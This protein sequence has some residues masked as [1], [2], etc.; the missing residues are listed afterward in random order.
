[1][2]VTQDTNRVNSAAAGRNGN[3]FAFPEFNRMS[4]R[5]PIATYRLQ[6]NSGFRIADAE[7]IVDYLHELGISDLYASP[8]WTAKRGST[9]GYDVTDPTSLN[10][11]LGSDGDLQRLHDRLEER[12]MG[13]LLD[14]VPNHMAA[15]TSNPW[16][17][18]VLENGVN[19]RYA[20]FF[21]IVWH[22]TTGVT[23]A[24]NKVLLPILGRRYSEA[25]AS[26]E[27]RLSFGRNGFTIQYYDLHFPVGLQ[28]YPTILSECD[29]ARTTRAI[30]AVL[31]DIRAAASGQ[32]P[33]R[34]E[35]IKR[36]VDRRLWK[37]YS[38]SRRDRA[39]MDQCL[40]TINEPNDSTTDLLD[41]LID[42]QSYRL[43]HWRRAANDVNYRRFFDIS[44]LVGIRVERPDV[45]DAVHAKLLAWV[46]AG[47]VTGLRIDHVDGLFDPYRYLTTLQ[48]RCGA[49]L[50]G[51]GPE[52]FYVVVEKIIGRHETLPAWFPVAGTSGYDWL[53]A[54]NRLLM[55]DDGV[56]RAIEIYDR[57]T[58]NRRAFQGIVHRRKKQVLATLFGGDLRML[59]N[60]LV[61]FAA[62][63][64][65][66]RYCSSREIVQALIEIS[67]CLPVYRTYIHGLSV[68]DRDRRFIEEAVAKARTMN[69]LDPV[70]YDFV[71]RVLLLENP[72]GGM[73]QSWLELVMRWQQFTG[74]VTAKGVE[75]TTFYVYNALISLNEVGG[76]AEAAEVPAVDGLHRFNLAHAEQWP[77][78]MNATSTHDTK[79]A[80]DARA[81][82]DVITEVTDEWESLLARW[83]KWNAGHKATVRGQAVPDANEEILIYQ[84]L[85]GMW[86]LDARETRRIRPRLAQFLTKA[87]REAKTYTSWLDVNEEHEAALIRFSSRILSRNGRFLPSF[88]KFHEKTAFHGAINSLS[89]VLLKINSPGTPDFYQGTELWDFSM[90][91]PDNRRTV[92]FEARARLL[93]RM[94]MRGAKGTHGFLRELLADWQSGAVKMHVTQKALAFRNEHAGLFRSGTYVPLP[95]RG[96]QSSHVFAFARTRAL[97][98][99]IT[100]VPRLTAAITRPGK[101]PLG[102][103]VWSST[104]VELPAGAPDG[105][106]ELFSGETITAR[107][108]SR[109]R[110]L[111]ADILKRFP[112]ALLYPDPAKRNR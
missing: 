5:V 2:S 25:L 21:D 49:A 76:E 74:P 91:D 82:I 99:S 98:W 18:D 101:W 3:S 55:H 29:G 88:L 52:P 9:H 59:G 94:R 70:V 24:E 72:P 107:G 110:L 40:A 22:P 103:S 90:V 80:E 45:F 111:L 68:A 36:S 15:T 51:K 34:L 86:P 32:D 106:C 61:E 7:A 39:A 30:A 1:M 16:W 11:E 44:D 62:S 84:A 20:E 28:S 31:V 50:N 8:I 92:D 85:V 105:W 54:A 53:A 108:R 67:A 23:N 102:E 77:H 75:D 81:R 43:I 93:R 83:S 97:E 27:I 10:P 48:Q 60:Q 71:R 19:S 87:A 46:A 66:V 96:A 73:E 63:D 47:I 65:N 100:V 35:A 112:V 58:E 14:I 41:T 89:Q 38:G 26:R 78:G 69:E 37:S 6:L 95:G 57:F 12:S 4:R 79:R 17:R 109:K 56:R 64:R 42:Q 104:E 13:L 33:E